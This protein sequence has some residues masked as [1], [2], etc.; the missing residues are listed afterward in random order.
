MNIYEELIVIA[1]LTGFFAV[2]TFIACIIV[3]I[4]DYCE[5][6]Y[7]YVPYSIPN[8][9]IAFGVLVVAAT[10]FLCA[11][12][13]GFT[14]PQ[15]PAGTILGLGY[16]IMLYKNTVKTN[17]WVALLIT[18]LQFILSVFAGLLAMGVLRPGVSTNRIH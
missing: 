18:P 8:L 12:P 7:D 10:V 6:A 11:E 4:K 17:W 16:L 1:Y 5:K 14:H 3:G 13:W 9:A 2:A 15:L